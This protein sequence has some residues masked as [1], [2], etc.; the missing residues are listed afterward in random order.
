MTIF[1]RLLPLLSDIQLILP[2]QL[3]LNIN[4]AYRAWKVVPVGGTETD[5]TKY[6]TKKPKFDIR[7]SS[8][9]LKLKS[10]NE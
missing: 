9:G 2:S 4:M 3:Q 5:Q 10:V 7:R 6:H 1:H 8:N